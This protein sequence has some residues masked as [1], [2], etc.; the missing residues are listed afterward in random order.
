[1]GFFSLLFGIIAVNKGLGIG[2]LWRLHS[3]RSVF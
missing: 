1:L 3:S 2:Q